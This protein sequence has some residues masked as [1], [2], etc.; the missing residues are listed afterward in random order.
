MPQTH[1]HIYVRRRRQNRTELRNRMKKKISQK[2]KSKLHSKEILKVQTL[3]DV[4]ETRGNL[5]KSGDQY[6]LQQNNVF[7]HISPQTIFG[8]LRKFFFLKY[9]RELYIIALRRRTQRIQYIH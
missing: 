2:Y 4:K 6:F 3:S 5:T 1:A 7:F 9:A 8:T